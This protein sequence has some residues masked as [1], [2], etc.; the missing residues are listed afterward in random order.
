M[1]NNIKMFLLAGFLGCSTAC[2]LQPVVPYQPDVPP[3]HEPVF[4]S[5]PAVSTEAGEP[6]VQGAPGAPMVAY[7]TS[8][9]RIQSLDPITIQFGGMPEQQLM[10]VVVDENGR[11]NLPHL[12]PVKVAGMT[13]SELEREIERLYVEGQI[14]RNVSINVTMTAKSY[15]VQG[16]VNAPG[17][18]PLTSG[19]TLMQAVAAA[20]GL[21]PYASDKVTITRHGQ[22]VKYD[23]GKI[24]RNPSRDVKIEAGDL[25]KVH[26]SWF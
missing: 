20:R 12:D 23:M 15:Y 6:V 18:F 10:Q 19:T 7:D 4:M 24:E 13:T 5:T 16:E 22:I 26:R 8:A 9:Y 3:V 2:T 14:Y 21:S 11:I 25:I 1:K 17:Q